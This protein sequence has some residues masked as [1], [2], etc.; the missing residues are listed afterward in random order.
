[1]I[2]II[3]NLFPS[4]P[5]LIK[6]KTKGAKDSAEELALRKTAFE[7]IEKMYKEKDGWQ[8]L[9]TQIVTF[10][11][12]GKFSIYGYKRYS[13]IRLVW[14]PELDLGFFGGDPDN[15]T[16]PRYNLDATF[17]RAYD[18]NGNPLNTSANYLKFNKNLIMIGIKKLLYF[19]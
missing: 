13:D 14:I 16:Y 4:N 6:K 3:V 10:Y 2:I 9:R 11:S 15:F 8:G 17:W 7:D 18:E 12:G 5:A 19:S 1:M